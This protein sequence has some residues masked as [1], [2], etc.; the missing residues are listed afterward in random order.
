M[1]KHM[2]K[3]SIAIIGAG[4]S[5]LSA[6]Q[7]LKDVAKVTIFDKSRGVGGRMSTRYAGEYEFDHGAQYFTA[8]DPDFLKAVESGIDA[9]VIKPWQARAFYLKDGEV[10]ADT[11][12]PRFVGSPRMNSWP[13]YLAKGQDVRL[14]YRL[15]YMKRE[16]DG[17]D[18]E[19]EDGTVAPGFD[20]IIC[21]VPPAQAGLLLPTNFP[22]MAQVKSAK[23]D[24]CFA[25]MIG[26]REKPHVSWDTLRVAESPVAWMAMNHAKPERKVSPSLIIHADADWSEAY[27]DADRGWVQSQLLSEASKLCNADL[28]SAPHIALHRWLYASLGRSVDI[29]CLYDKALNIAVCGD[30]CQ[31]GRV[32]GAW[33]SG[34]AA[35]NTMLSRL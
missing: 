11:G 33:L 28:T 4:I 19:F 12:R 15:S 30:W 6:A 8:Q 2:T 17:W 24:A 26:F 14:E 10:E 9:G 1:A 18:L 16:V 7:H 23:L 29:A 32:Q 35:A 34:R 22:H 20:G 21:T 25:L 31:G 5:G 3:P 27:K 13:K